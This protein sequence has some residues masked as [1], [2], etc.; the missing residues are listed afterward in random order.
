MNDLKEIKQ[1]VVTYGLH[2]AYVREMI[3][4][5]A[6][7]IKVTPHAWLQLVSAVLDDGP[8]LMFKCYFREEVKILEQQGKAKRLETSQDQILG[9][10]TYVDPQVQALYDEK[11]LSQCH[12]AA[13]NAWDRIRELGK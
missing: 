13:L 10:G 5:W 1:V 9:E 3:K 11:I 4:T 8:Q 12:K 6:S 7:S 2:S